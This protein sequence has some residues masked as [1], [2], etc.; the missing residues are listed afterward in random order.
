[1]L[2]TIM[3]FVIKGLESRHC[4]NQTTLKQRVREEGLGKKVEI[5]ESFEIGHI[6]L[7][8]TLPTAETG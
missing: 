4:K 6:S 7:I 1:M 2:P 5:A 3:A 8:C